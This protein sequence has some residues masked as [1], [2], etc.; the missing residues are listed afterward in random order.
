MRRTFSILTVVFMIFSLTAAQKTPVKQ[1]RVTSQAVAS[2][3]NGKLYTLDLSHGGTVYS[4]EQDVELS[5]VQVRTS[6]G[7]LAMTE[8]AK[9][10]G[11]SGKLLVGQSRD[12]FSQDLRMISAAR[13]AG[14]SCDTLVCKCKGFGDCYLMGKDGVCKGIT[15]CDDK[16]CTC[17]RIFSRNVS[18]GPGLSQ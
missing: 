5:R 17:W 10:A 18:R 2:Q 14:Y 4:V 7:L 3:S 9:Q 6:S 11:R 16:G 1:I 13:E 15:V 12:V 8:L